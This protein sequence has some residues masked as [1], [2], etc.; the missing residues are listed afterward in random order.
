MEGKNNTYRISLI[1]V[2]VT[3][4]VG[5]IGFQ[6]VEFRPYFKLI[7]PFHLLMISAL[8]ILNNKENHFKVFGFVLV[9][10][11]LGYFVEVIGVKTGL[12]FGFYNYG[13]TLGIKLLDVP[14]MIG[15]NWFLLTFSMGMTILPLVKNKYLATLLCTIL[16]VGLDFFIEPVAV[17]MEFWSWKDSIIPLKNYIGWFF[18][19]L[20]IMSIFNLFNFKTTNPLAKYILASQLV[21]FVILGWSN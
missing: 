9:S 16:L 17:K 13:P 15:V 1:I 5:I 7:T 12:I 10:G 4:L 11:I 8:L 6:W 3:Y 18:T 20:L 2:L 19:C 14:L 21:F